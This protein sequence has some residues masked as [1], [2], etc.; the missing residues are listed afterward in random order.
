MLARARGYDG[1]EGCILGGERSCDV[2]EGAGLAAKK[3]RTDCGGRAVRGAGGAAG[4]SW[5]I[6]ERLHRRGA[7]GGGFRVG[8]GARF[9]VLEARTG[10]RVGF[11][12]GEARDSRS[13]RSERLYAELE[14][15]RGIR[16]A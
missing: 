13:L 2:G 3:R 12:T 10:V 1:G 11:A 6:E 15:R 16:G 14:A 4:D 7:G 8:G 9:V 5:E